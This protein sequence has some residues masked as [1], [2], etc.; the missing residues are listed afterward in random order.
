MCGK[1]HVPVVLRS[2]LLVCDV[3]PKKSVKPWVSLVGVSQAGLEII[4]RQCSPC[5]TPVLRETLAKEVDL[6]PTVFQ[7][8]LSA[9]FFGGP[10]ANFPLS[11]RKAVQCVKRQK[12]PN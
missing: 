10:F 12:Q 11:K 4:R 9:C 2:V 5:L 3:G 6:W 8:A 7:P 1:S